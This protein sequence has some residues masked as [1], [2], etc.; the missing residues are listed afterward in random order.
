MAG[1]GAR[2]HPVYDRLRRPAS[3]YRVVFVRRR[4]S[5]LVVRRAVLGLALL[6]ALPLAPTEGWAHAVL[7]R[8]APAARAAL[9]RPP[10]RVQLWFN[11][12]LE[13]AYSTVSVW[14]DA[15]H[16]VDAADAAVDPA[17]PTRLSVGVPALGAGT[18]TVK[19]RVLSVDG[20]LVE[21]Q[22]SFTVRGAR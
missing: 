8:S 20:H 11:E 14:D 1:D 16:R 18:Y 22:L 12:R 21:S 13:S 10:E 5:P 15:G 4:L 7:V 9:A 2:A 17:E 3:V 19:F 6:V